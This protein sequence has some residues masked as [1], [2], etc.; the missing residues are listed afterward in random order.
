MDDR[1]IAQC[2]QEDEYNQTNNRTSSWDN[3]NSTHDK[4]DAF[5]ATTIGLYNNKNTSDESSYYTLVR[6]NQYDY[7]NLVETTDDAELA[8]HLQAEQ[9]VQTNKQ[10]FLQNN[11][12][13]QDNGSF[14]IN[15]ENDATIAYEL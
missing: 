14:N 11:Y 6:K 4:V 15:L 5:A 7:N 2:L 1:A 3:N 10:I 12:H 9:Y 13:E 8:A